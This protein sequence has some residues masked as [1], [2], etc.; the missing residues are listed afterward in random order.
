MEFIKK[1]KSYLTIVLVLI[2][3]FVYYFNPTPQTGLLKLH[4]LM[5]ILL[6]S[7]ALGIPIPGEP[8]RMITAVTINI[9]VGLVSYRIS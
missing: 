6:W 3:S 2:F 4:Q 9:S 5:L 1:Y 8:I 7:C